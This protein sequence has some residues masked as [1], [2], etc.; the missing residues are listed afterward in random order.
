MTPEG[1]RF[2]ESERLR[3]PPAAGRRSPVAGR[4]NSGFFKR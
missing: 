2:S 4:R 1:S 3:R